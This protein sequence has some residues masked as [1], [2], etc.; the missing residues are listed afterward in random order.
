MNRLQSL[1]L[2]LA[3]CCGLATLA[4]RDP[5][6]PAH[7]EG[8]LSLR[9]DVGTHRV[10]LLHYELA[11]PG[12][13]AL[14]GDFDVSG[15]GTVVNAHIGAIPV[16]D[17]YQI[18]LTADTTDG[19][20]H[21]EGL[22]EAFNVAAG[23]TTAVRVIVSC[24]DVEDTG[25]TTD[26]SSTDTSSTDTSSVTDGGVSL[27]IPFNSCPEITTIEAS[28]T[29]V[30]VG[31]TVSLTATANDPDVGDTLSFSWSELG[32]AFADGS[33]AS[34]LCSTPG[35]H[36]LILAVLDGNCSAS[37]DVTVECL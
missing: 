31:S 34:Y 19:A 16:G 10:D 8:A 14:S 12:D 23:E 22:S 15:A 25:T 13:P 26:T 32:S 35:S 28:P 5:D 30:S 20:Q 21:C 2:L 37:R 17:G 1:L 18:L 33:S 36:V 27:E 7:E 24:R 9:V 4:C 11:R 29:S 6:E 3:T